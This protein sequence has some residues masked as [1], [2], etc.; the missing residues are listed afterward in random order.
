MDCSE[1]ETLRVSKTLRVCNNLRE[2]G[3]SGILLILL[4]LAVDLFT[5]LLIT[6]GWLPASA[7]W[8][9]HLALAVMI[10]WLFLRM[11][12]QDL[13]PLAFWFILGVSITGVSVAF[14]HNQGL[15]STVWGWWQLFQYPLIGLFAYLQASW[16][17]NFPR[18]LRNGLVF[19]LALEVVVQLFQYLSGMQPGDQLSGTFGRNGTGNLVIFILL[20]MSFAFGNWIATRKF[21][22][23]LF[24]LS[25]A[26]ISSTLGEMKFFIVAAALI[27]GLAL[28]IYMVRYK[29]SLRVIPY[30]VLFAFCIFIFILT[31][32][33]IV[34]GADRNPIETYIHN[35]DAYISYT[36]RVER[37][38]ENGRYYYDI[39]RN[40]ALRLGWESIRKDPLIFLFGFGIGSRSESRSL[41]VEGIGIEESGSTPGLVVGTSLL[42]MIHEL[43][44]VGMVLLSVF[45]IWV[46]YHQMRDIRLYPESPAVETRYALIL[47]TTLFPLW[48]W[49][50]MAW[51]LRV[52]MLVYW[53]ALGYVLRESRHSVQSEVLTG[54]SITGGGMRPKAA[55]DE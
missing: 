50:N 9:S 1:V 44:M 19:V 35:P 3:Y 52:P 42:V 14:I 45:Y 10:I 32:N 23:S 15:I 53:V 33:A 5:P 55:Q 27:S 29:S 8:F 31:Y 6:Y 48:L 49:Y 54:A 17:R 41:G 25:L 40:Y 22:L 16:P 51:T 20:V 36:N 30:L 11:L 21:T 4:A 38:Y 24:A 47:F 34:P 18:L 12:H 26:I 46:I 7:R 13:V 28:V 39:G 2:G 43:G 37:H